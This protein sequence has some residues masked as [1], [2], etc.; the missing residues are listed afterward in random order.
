MVYRKP[1][2]NTWRSEKLY[3]IMN[4]WTEACISFPLSLKL[5]HRLLAFGLAGGQ[6]M[7]LIV[8]ISSFT[9]VQFDFLHKLDITSYLHVL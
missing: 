7:N 2:G 3:Q 6:D 4:Y 8:A 1:H 5:R 9:F